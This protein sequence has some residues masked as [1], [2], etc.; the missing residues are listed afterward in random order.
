MKTLADDLLGQGHEKQQV[1]RTL[2]QAR[3]DLGEL[4]KNATPRMPREYI[5]E[6]N[7]NRYDG[8]SLGGSFEYFYDYYGEK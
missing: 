5:Y 1:A 8:D 7:I 6:L 4:Y 3:H 2:H